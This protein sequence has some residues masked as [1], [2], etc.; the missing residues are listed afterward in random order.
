MHSTMLNLSN[1]DKQF[2]IAKGADEHSYMMI[3]SYIQV[4][5]IPFDFAVV[6]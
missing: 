4:N 3:H 1:Y 5:T 6:G 2:Q